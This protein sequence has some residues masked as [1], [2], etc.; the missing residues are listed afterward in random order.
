MIKRFDLNVV[1]I[2]FFIECR[3]EQSD[4]KKTILNKS[5]DN[6]LLNDNAIDFYYGDENQL[7]HYVRDIPHIANGIAY[8]MGIT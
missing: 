1:S 3:I 6:S 5:S 8:G 7:F 4:R 2:I